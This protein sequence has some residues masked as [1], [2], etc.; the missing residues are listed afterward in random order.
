MAEV[1]M[2]AALKS[3]RE[4]AGWSIAD[5][6]RELRRRG[7]ADELPSLESII[8][9]WK[10]WEAGSKP[11][12]PYRPLLNRLF[13]NP[14]AASVRSISNPSAWRRWLAFELR[15]LREQHG[16]SQRGANKACGWSGARLAY[17]EQ[18]QQNVTLDDLERLLTLYEVPPDRWATYHDA[19]ERARDVG[20][21]QRYDQREVPN[22]LSLFVGLEQ[23][24]SDLR[25]FEPIV[26]HGLLQ[27]PEYATAVLRSDLV[28]RTE[29]HVTRLVELRMARQAALTRASDPLRLSVVM[30]ES[31]LHRTTGNDEVMKAQLGHLVAMARRPNVTLQ[32]LP[33]T[34]AVFTQVFGTFFI[35]GFPWESDPG[36]VYI[37]NRTGAVYLEQ[38]HEIE[39]HS[40]VFQQL[41]VLALSPTESVALIEDVMKGGLP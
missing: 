40:L 22:W 41:S 1:L 30:D 26:V 14:D 35:L 39:G 3:A 20:W 28:P 10:R 16:L 12:I 6:A 38:L 8:R 24:A 34:A 27:T 9:S 5:A 2:G 17:I 29:T 18:A 7:G 11:G 37:E 32:V 36:L 21:W 33:L 31:V 23:G 25:A 15:R 19:A 13:G 4:A